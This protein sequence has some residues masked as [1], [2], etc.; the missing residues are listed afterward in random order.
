LL[1]RPIRPEDELLY[2]RLI[3]R[4]TTDDMRMRFFIGHPQH[5]L[6]LIARLTQ[7]DYAREMAFVAI[8]QRSGQLLGVARLIADP[9]YRRAEYAVIVA[10]DLKG[11]GLG[12]SLMQHLIDYARHEG[13]SE[14]FGDVLSENTAMLQLCREFGFNIAAQ[15]DDASLTR[16]TLDLAR[17]PN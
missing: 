14:L 4:V 13:L 17:E 1:Q 7:I 2:S 3:E 5:S 11:R 16:V 10:S 8:D 12:W 6:K 9:D 15:P